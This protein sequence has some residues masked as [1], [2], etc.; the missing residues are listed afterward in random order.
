MAE[1][2]LFYTPLNRVSR[3]AKAEKDGKGRFD[4]ALTGDFFIFLSHYRPR[5]VMVPI[6]VIKS[7]KQTKVV[8]H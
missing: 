7:H 6:N 1:C 4:S 3:L 8:R 5:A 2:G